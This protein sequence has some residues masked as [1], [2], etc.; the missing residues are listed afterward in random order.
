MEWRARLAVRPP[1]AVHLLIDPVVQLAAGEDMPGHSILA[2]GDG[3]N[4]AGQNLGLNIL[5][6]ITN[7]AGLHGMDGL[8]YIV[9]AC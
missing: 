4:G 3:A 8:L 5:R 6:T 9:I 7:R 2:I 1:C